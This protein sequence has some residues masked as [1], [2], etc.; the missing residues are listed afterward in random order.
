MIFPLQ[1]EFHNTQPL[2]AVESRIRQELAEFE[3]FYNRLLTCR[4]E[5]EAP[6]HDR[7]GSVSKVRIDLGVPAKD[8]ATPGE[9]RGA[10]GKDNT[11]HLEVR[12]QRKDA[13][14]AVHA[15]FNVARRRLK[16]FSGDSYKHH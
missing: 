7:R 13:S 10:E 9:L 12:A 11:E 5:V 2:E 8:A 15:A 3:K 1:I 6:K 16:E 4:V 14:M